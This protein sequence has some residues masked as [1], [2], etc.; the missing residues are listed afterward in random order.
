MSLL[1]KPSLA[2]ITAIVGLPMLSE[3]IYSPS[4]PSIAHALKTSETWMEYT[5]SIYLLAFSLGTLFWGKLSDKYGRKICLLLGLLIYIVGCIGCFM[6][7]SIEFLLL[8]RFIQAFGGSTGS[9]L[10][11]AICRDAFTKQ[12]QGAAYATIGA[13]LALAPA[14]APFIGGLITQALGWRSVFGLLIALGV[15]VFATVAAALPETH[16]NRNA[17]PSLWTVFTTMASDTSVIGFGLIVGLCNGIIFSYYG[18]GSFYLIELLK[19]SPSVF[20][21]TFILIALA[22]LLGG[23]VSRNLHKRG[24]SSLE[25]LQ[26]GVYEVVFFTSIFL[27]GTLTIKHLALA[28]TFNV[29]LTLGCVMGVALGIRTLIPSALAL[30]T[31]KYTAFAGVSTA[32]FG[33][34]YYGIISSCTFLVAHFRNNNLVTMPLFFWVIS[35]LL[36]I[37]YSK[38][39]APVKQA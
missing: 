12:E 31:Q 33:C 8:S 36:L 38:M 29:A 24:W 4:L 16:F 14:I 11:Q 18:E 19:L 28:S 20:G 10:G 3:D 23:L 1:E 5:L 37:V 9:V 13:S 39:I 35:L 32:I 17:A 26:V 7:N 21:T 27:L 22:T 30:S 2:I 6:S 34:F 25:V 15:V